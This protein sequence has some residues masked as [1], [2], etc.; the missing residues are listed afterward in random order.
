MKSGRDFPAFDTEGLFHDAMSL[1]I[2]VLKGESDTSDLDWDAAG[3]AAAVVVVVMDVKEEEDSLGL[4]TEVRTCK[5]SETTF[6]HAEK[7]MVCL[8]WS[9][10]CCGASCCADTDAVDW[11]MLLKIKGKRKDV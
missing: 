9:Q 6:F 4:L 7:S 8:L 2:V 11:S 3:T 10:G 1:L 5:S